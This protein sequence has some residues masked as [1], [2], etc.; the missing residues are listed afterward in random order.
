MNIDAW[1]EN[2][3]NSGLA[4]IDRALVGEASSRRLQTL[5]AMSL[6]ERELDFAIVATWRNV[7][8]TVV[9]QTR[10]G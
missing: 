10:Q 3:L 8:G 2:G 5:S 6:E 9:G 4:T 7:R 1:R